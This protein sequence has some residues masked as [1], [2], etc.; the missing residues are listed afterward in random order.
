MSMRALPMAG[1]MSMR[2]CTAVRRED[3]VYRNHTGAVRAPVFR[4]WAVPQV[5]CCRSIRE[6][7]YDTLHK[8]AF[9]LPAVIKKR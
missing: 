6:N 8:A 3:T 9:V 7:P 2:V 5:I 4:L 1:Q